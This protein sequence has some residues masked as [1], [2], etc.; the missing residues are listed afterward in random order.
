[1]TNGSNT[2]EEACR[3]NIA[4]RSVNEIASANIEQ[5]GTCKGYMWNSSDSQHP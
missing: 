1:M 5:T 4:K 2:N 3:S